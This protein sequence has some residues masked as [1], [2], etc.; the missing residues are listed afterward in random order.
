[1]TPQQKW[2]LGIAATAAAL[3]FLFWHS[4]RSEAASLPGGNGN[5]K[6]PSGQDI[7]LPGGMSYTPGATLPSDYYSETP[8]YSGGKTYSTTQAP[9]SQYD[10]PQQYQ[11]V[12]GSSSYTPDEVQRGD[13]TVFA[14]QQR[15]RDLGY[16]PG[17]IDG[18]YGPIT[19][20]AVRD[21]Q[22]DNGLTVDGAMGPRTRA[23]IDAAYGTPSATSGIG[24]RFWKRY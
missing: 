22:A 8:A 16:D 4:S 19:Q 24:G 23:A 21:F 2:G 18:R 10:Y 1:M 20:R 11:P 17:P 3:G 7:P 14:Y 13:P 9:V 6:L 5:G 15:L 12:Q